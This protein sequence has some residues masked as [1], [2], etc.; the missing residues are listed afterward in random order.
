MAYAFTDAGPC[1]SWSGKGPLEQTE[2]EARGKKRPTAAMVPRKCNAS[3][4]P[5][6]SKTWFLGVN[7]LAE[8]AAFP[9][10]KA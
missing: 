4:A 8:E 7:D 9:K 10:D 1:E 3:V 5:S 6:P 2:L